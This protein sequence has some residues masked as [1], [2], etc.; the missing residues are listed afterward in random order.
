VQN[1]KRHLKQQQLVHAFIE[2]QH[3]KINKIAKATFI[4][5]SIV[6]ANLTPNLPYL[7][8]SPE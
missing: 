6:R 2:Q 4:I 5:M 3:I 8:I 1:L 7:S